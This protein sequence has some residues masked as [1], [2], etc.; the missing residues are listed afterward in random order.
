[1]KSRD[2]LNVYLS[3]VAVLN[4]KL[5]NLH[6]NVKGMNFMPVHTYTEA[7]Y[8][9]LF[10]VYDE[11][12]ELEKMNGHYPP[13]SYNEYMALTTVKEL[14]S[15]KSY[16][17]KEVLSIVQEELKALRALAAEIKELEEEGLFAVVN[18]MEDHMAYY[19][20]ELWFIES[21]MA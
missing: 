21:M 6:W 1:M 13:A 4:A 18:L 20:K 9:K 11:V 17:D 14:P 12:A 10:A 2:K 19:D 3:N 16:T 5:H 8:D 7:I 15:D